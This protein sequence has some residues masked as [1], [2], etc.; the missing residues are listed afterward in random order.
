[1]KFLSSNGEYFR[2]KILG[3]PF[4]VELTSSKLLVVCADGEDKIVGACGVRSLL[5]VLAGLYVKEDYRGYGV[6][7]KLVEKTIKAAEKR[8]L[9]FL[10]LTV[11]HDNVAFHIYTKFGF[12][13]VMFLKRSR[14]KLMVR[15]LTFM[16]KLAYAFFS[17][18]CFLLPNTFLSYV[19]VWLYRRTL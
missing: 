11:S 19:H 17:R 7:K 3:F 5:N 2:E 10:T 16:W 9:G 18:I 4:A 12:K 8:R 13:E 1:M 15:P 14:Q 6:G